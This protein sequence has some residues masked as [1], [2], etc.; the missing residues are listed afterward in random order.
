MNNLPDELQLHIFTFIKVLS[1]EL[2]PLLEINKSIR[3][4]LWEKE[5]KLNTYPYMSG[6]SVAC[7]SK[8]YLEYLNELKMQRREA[9]EE[10]IMNDTDDEIEVEE[11]YSYLNFPPF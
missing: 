10:C 11:H 2:K 9:A 4:L 6:E 7:I 8:S 5:F 1:S 3:K